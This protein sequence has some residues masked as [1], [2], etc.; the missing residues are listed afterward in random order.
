M[1]NSVLSASH[2]FSTLIFITTLLGCPSAHLTD[3]EKHVTEAKQF[4]QQNRMS[5]WQRLDVSP[6]LQSLRA[7]PKSLEEQK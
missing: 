3:E 2:P 6:A 1:P 5:K 7:S 4:L